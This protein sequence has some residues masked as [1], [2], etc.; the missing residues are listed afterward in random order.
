V[1]SRCCREIGV[2]PTNSLPSQSHIA[3]DSQSVSQSVLVSTD[4]RFSVTGTVFS[5]WCAI[6]EERTGLSFVRVIVSSNMSFIRMYIIF[7]FY[8]LLKVCTSNEY[9]VEGQNNVSA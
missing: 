4:I 6:Y 2:A 5:V 7:T 8:M 9:F 1:R 3:T